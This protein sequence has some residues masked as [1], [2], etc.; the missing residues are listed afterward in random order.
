M[1]TNPDMSETDSVLD[2][3]SDFEIEDDSCIGSLPLVVEIPGQP[4][5][6]RSDDSMRAEDL[7]EAAMAA[8]LNDPFLR[9]P[10]DQA[11]DL[12]RNDATPDSQTSCTKTVLSASAQPHP[13]PRSVYFKAH[14]AVTGFRTVSSEVQPLVGMSAMMFPYIWTHSLAMHQ[15]LNSPHLLERTLAYASLYGQR[16]APTCI[17]SDPSPFYPI[18]SHPATPF[19]QLQEKSPNG[20]EKERKLEKG[21]EALMMCTSERQQSSEKL[22]PA[23]PHSQQQSQKTA[24]VHGKRR[25]CERLIVH[26]QEKISHRKAAK[27]KHDK[28]LLN[29][30]DEMLPMAARTVQR[31]SAG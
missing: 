10:S 16:P 20:G 25:S 2:I 23:Q 5:E 14:E 13:M 17:R 3:D 27:R 29:Q 6:A 19:C 18:C 28:D 21:H 1:A 12:T 7:T 30:L 24:S 31:K 9:C 26:E 4:G 15:H 11:G 8:H 22:C